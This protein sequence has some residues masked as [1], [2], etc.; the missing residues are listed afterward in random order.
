MLTL[1]SKDKIIRKF[2]KEEEAHCLDRTRTTITLPKKESSRTAY[3]RP[4]GARAKGKEP[5]SKCLS[6]CKV[7]D[8]K[9]GIPDAI[10]IMYP[11]T[12]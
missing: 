9:K 4:R 10:S 5:H 12:R 2:E 6:S 8:W 11:R 1:L 3:R 7:D